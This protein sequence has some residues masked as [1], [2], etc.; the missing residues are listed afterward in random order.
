[1]RTMELSAPV[2]TIGVWLF[3]Q[4]HSSRHAA[5]QQVIGDRH[6]PALG[7]YS[8]ACRSSREHSQP[9]DGRL[10]RR[11]SRRDDPRWHQHICR[12]AAAA[13]S[14]RGAHIRARQPRFRTASRGCHLR[15]IAPTCVGASERSVCVGARPPLA[16]YPTGGG[17]GR[18]RR[19]PKVRGRR[20]R[21][22]LGPHPPHPARGCCSAVARFA[23]AQAPPRAARRAPTASPQ[24]PT[25]RAPSP[26]PLAS[27]PTSPPPAAVAFTR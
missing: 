14:R 17:L 21:L 20:Q 12:E 8:F 26:P 9:T 25:S 10:R 18:L 11:A 15:S 19:L 27:P 7:R 16:A 23:L 6:A 2:Q 24:R 22:E 1:M 5:A 3:G 13:A 4:C